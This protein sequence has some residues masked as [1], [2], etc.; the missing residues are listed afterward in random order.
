VYLN[1]CVSAIH[2][3][4]G[5]DPEAVA[6]SHVAGVL[7]EP[8]GN[9]T[10][11]H[12]MIAMEVITGGPIEIMQSLMHGEGIHSFLFSRFCTEVCINPCKKLCFFEATRNSSKELRKAIEWL[13]SYAKQEVIYLY[14]VK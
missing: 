14:I 11:H 13:R 3:I 4:A 12:N 9:G 8:T 7:Q 2:H 6:P 1:Y 5:R 10:I